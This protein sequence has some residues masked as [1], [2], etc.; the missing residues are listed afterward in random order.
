[1]IES[2]VSANE[3]LAAMLDVRNAHGWVA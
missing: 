3:I 1:V 2:P